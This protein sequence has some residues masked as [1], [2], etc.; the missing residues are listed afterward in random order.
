MQNDYD[1][2]Y[3]LLNWAAPGRLGDKEQFREYYEAPIKMAQK[4]AIN[5]EAL[6]K[7]TLTS[8]FDAIAIFLCGDQIQ[9]C[10]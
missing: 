2:L 4:K 6:G 7:V 8:V 9:Q 5:E 10:E 1:E 3:T